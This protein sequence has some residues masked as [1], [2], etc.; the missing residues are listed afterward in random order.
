MT[1]AL[2]WRSAVVLLWAAVSSV[3]VISFRLQVGPALNVALLADKAL[4]APNVFAVQEELH[5]FTLEEPFWD[6]EISSAWTSLGAWS[7][8]EGRVAAKVD[9]FVKANQ[10]VLLASRLASPSSPRPP[11]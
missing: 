1:S 11:R 7:A 5:S 10:A 2:A 4:K 6:F 8:S 3:A 9:L